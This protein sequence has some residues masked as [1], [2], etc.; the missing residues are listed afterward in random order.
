[1][2]LNDSNKISPLPHWVREC[3]QSSGHRVQHVV[4]E[5]GISTGILNIA[6]E[7][8]FLLKPYSWEEKGIR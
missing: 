2:K 3:M 4:S 5:D 1:M 7:V 8:V 6:R